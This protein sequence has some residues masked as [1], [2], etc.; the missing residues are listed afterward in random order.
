MTLLNNK[1][2]V[3]TIFISILFVYLFSMIYTVMSQRHFYADGAHFFLS[4]V[5]WNDFMKMLLWRSI[6]LLF[7]RI[8]CHILFKISAHGKH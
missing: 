4:F 5:R 7:Y 6:W 1:K 2:F 3:I 8:S